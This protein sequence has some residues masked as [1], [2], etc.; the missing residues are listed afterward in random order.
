MSMGKFS[1]ITV[2]SRYDQ[3]KAQFRKFSLFYDDS[4]TPLGIVTADAPRWGAPSPLVVKSPEAYPLLVR[5]EIRWITVTEG[6]CYEINAPLDQ[7]KAE[8]LWKEQEQNNPDDPFRQYVFGIAP[9]GG[10]AVWLCSN[11]RS[12][13]LH[14]LYAEESERTAEEEFI[15]PS[16]PEMEMLT[17]VLLPFDRLQSH[18]RQY[19]YRMVPLEEYFDGEKWQRYPNDDPYYE[20]INIDGVEVRRLDGTYDY[21]DSE[22]VLRYHESGKPSRITARWHQGESAYF[23]HFWLDE[24]EVSFFFNSLCKTFPDAKADFLLRIDTRANR[25]E[26]AMTSDGL[27][28]RWLNYTQYIVFHE[29]EEIGRS[30][31]YSK[32]DGE[33]HWF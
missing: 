7:A 26:L 12:V 20:G 31:N 5:M 28:I 22:A 9:H 33:W 30:K 6:K 10:V 29:D 14:W 16:D 32:K 11:K 2:L 17:N 23:A 24:D 27:P 1:Y 13:L 21:T 25:Y 18:M 8:E 15:F 4:E 3:F 19:T